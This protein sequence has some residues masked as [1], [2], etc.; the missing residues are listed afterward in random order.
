MIR[1]AVFLLFFLGIPAHAYVNLSGAWFGNGGYKLAQNELVPYGNCSTC[2]ITLNWDGTTAKM[3]G[4]KNEMIGGMLTLQGGASQANNVSVFLTPLTGPGS[5]VL[6]STPVLCSNTTDYTT[7]DFEVFVATYVQIIGMSELNYTAPPYEERQMPIDYRNPCTINSNNDCIQNSP[8]LYQTRPISYKY[9]PDALIPQECVTNGFNVGTNSSQGIWFDMYLREN[10]STGTYSGNIVVMEGVTVSTTIPIQIT[11]YNGQLP[12]VPSYP[13]F[14]EMSEQDINYRINGA[15]R[16]SICTTPA[17]IATDEEFYKAAHRHRMIAIGDIPDITTNEFPSQ[18]YQIQLDGSLFTAAN[19]YRG[20]GINT[21]VPNYSLGTYG[22]WHDNPNWST[23]DPTAFCVALSSWSIWFQNNHPSVRTTI[24]LADE[25]TDFTQ[26]NQWSTW[27]S[28]VSSCQN[29]YKIH[30]WV[31]ARWPNVVSSAPYVDNPVSSAWIGKGMVQSQW[32]SA[33]SQYITSGSTQGWSYNGGPPWTGTFNADEDDGMGAWEGSWADWFKG[34]NGH[35]QWQTTSW[36]IQ[37]SGTPAENPL[38]TQAKTFG[39]SSGTSSDTAKGQFGQGYGNG[40]GVLFYP[41]TEISTYTASSYGVVG[42]IATVRLK[43]ARRGIEDHD[44]LTMAYAVNPTATMAI[45][46]TLVG[47][48]AL[49]DINCFTNSDCSYTYGGR[50][51]SQDPN[52]WEQARQ[53]LA[54]IIQ[55]GIPGFQSSN[56]SGKTKL[57]GNA[58]LQ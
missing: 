15:A 18:R 30:S 8:G 33:A 45:A 36:N 4:F 11:V 40:D 2:T 44:Y 34:I 27:M 24:Y 50:F 42:P 38:W 7:R 47:G 10:L 1:R 31:T 32:I 20:P 49:W 25:P 51:W 12:E 28:T 35:F 41:G 22:H 16:G 53:S 17:C 48:Q 13:W 23:T 46:S 14:A 6:S 19:H 37:G 54:T 9:M 26:T 39:F 3:A 58:T 57:T 29:S 52:V 56:I 21:A 43:Y 5:S 55:A